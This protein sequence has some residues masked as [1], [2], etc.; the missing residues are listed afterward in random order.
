M[1]SPSSRSPNNWMS[2]LSRLVSRRL[3]LASLPVEDLTQTIMR[4]AQTA[5]ERGDLKTA[6]TGYRLAVEQ[7]QTARTGTATFNDLIR[8]S[9]EAEADEVDDPFEGDVEGYRNEDE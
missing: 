1:R 7:A 5:E 2:R 8:K 4:L 6:M 9:L 3:S